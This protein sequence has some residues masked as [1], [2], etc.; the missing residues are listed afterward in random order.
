MLLGWKW[1]EWAAYG[2]RVPAVA[3]A[4]TGQVGSQG[5][6]GAA[7]ASAFTADSGAAFHGGCQQGRRA[8]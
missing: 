3:S 6:F 4:A 7:T 2:D 5:M 1:I 8:A